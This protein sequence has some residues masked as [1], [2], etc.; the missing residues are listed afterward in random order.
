MK[1]RSL[2]VAAAL[3]ATAA[4]LLTACGSGSDSSEG[5]DKISGAEQ[6][7]ARTAS[8]T[9]TADIA[10][11][12]LSLPSDITETFE[13]WKTGDT[14]K[15]TILTDAGHAQSAVTHAVV[16]GDP[17]DASLKFY[18][19]DTA[20]AGS[21]DWVKSIVDAGSTFTGAVRYYVPK[22]SV[23]DKTSAAVTYCSDESKAF[24]KNRKTEKVDKSPVTKDAYVLYST[25]LEKNAQ[26]VWQTTK[27]ESERGSKTCTP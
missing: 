25:R 16:K 26:G 1:R 7:A 22:I 19:A 17:E 10:R 15:D 8:P 12:D 6:S 9:P 4:S 23:F 18:Q 20:L 11:P 27:L 5:H 3:V 14:A 13:S 24:N 21:Q 2:P